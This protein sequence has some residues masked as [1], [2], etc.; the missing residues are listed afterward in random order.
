M[1]TNFT[2]RDFLKTSAAVGAAV[3]VGVGTIG[4][5][6]VWSEVPAAESDSPAEKLNI[7]FVGVNNQARFSI[8]NLRSQNIAALCDIDDRYVGTVSGEFPKAATYNDFRR[9]LDKE[10]TLDAVVVATPDHIHAH[11]TS[12]AIRLGK[13]VYCEKPLTHTVKE[14][15]LITELTAKHKVATQMGTQIHA[16]NNYREVVE[17]IQSG[18]IGK[19]NEVHVWVG[20]VWGGGD[21]PKELPDV[22]EHLH[23]DLWLGP[24]PKRPYHSTYLPSNWRRWWDF[25]GGALADMACH[26]TDLPFWALGL[27]RP[28]SIEAEGPEVHEE[29]APT[30]MRVR[31]EYPARG[32]Q[33]AVK[34]TWYDGN[35]I[36]REVAGHRVGGA[37]VMFIGEKGQMFADYG[38]WRLYP[39]DK[40]KDYQRPE[41]TIPRSIGHHNEWVKA[42]KEGTPTTCH[43]GYAGPLTEAV[44]LGNVS[45]RAGSR[46]DWDAES[47]TAKG[48]P[49]AEQ[50]ISREY[51][52]GWKLF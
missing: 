4:T 8:D 47:L 21:R 3:G 9:M 32:D 14:A 22:P 28:T 41:E 27:G 44:L 50:Y 18:A 40:Y 37:G 13:H 20:T 16:G 10:K 45:Y 42:C 7:G 15:R 23:W 11:A 43:F 24:A 25:G 26:Y 6:G 38:S 33:P 52:E 35:Q 17:I 36:P 48:C 5:L 49:E 39:E 31:Y 1:P 30:G 51:R 34:L 2:R 19:V 46:I 12:A 29:T